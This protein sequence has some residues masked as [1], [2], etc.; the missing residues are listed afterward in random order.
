MNT[1]GG[2][3]V[4]CFGEVLWDVLPTGAVPGGAPVNVAYHLQKLSK[5]AGVISRIGNDKNGDDLVKIFSDFGVN[6]Q[7]FQVDQKYNTG[8]VY[9]NSN[10]K[11]EVVYDIVMPS[12]W[13]F[14]ELNDASVNLAASADYFVF[15]SLAARQPVSQATLLALL[16]VANKKV[17][18]INLRPPHFKKDLLELL[19]HKADILKLNESE[20]DIISGWENDAANVYQKIDGI[21]QKY[22][23]DEV[24]VTLG[25]DGAIFS[26]TSG[27]FTHPG[28]KV[29]VADT[30]GSGDAF[31]AGLIAGFIDGQAPEVAL[32]FASGLGAFIASQHGAC[33]TYVLSQV[34]ALI[35]DVNAQK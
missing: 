30:V 33:P 29:T 16:E 28:F 15:G 6:T 5:N 9:A 18:D 10:N 4:V 34:D 20:L 21:K 1:L 13:D 3:Q 31:L 19:L 32:N 12:A 11:N 24:I 26:N 14:I 2:Q 8:L 22:S 7:Y 35:G 17:L 23:V 25:E 27:T